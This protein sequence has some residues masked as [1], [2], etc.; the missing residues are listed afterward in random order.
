MVD[1]TEAGSFKRPPKNPRASARAKLR[2]RLTWLQAALHNAEMAVDE[3]FAAPGRTYNREN[4]ERIKGA[5][6]DFR[7]ST[8]LTGDGLD[9]IPPIA[10]D[11]LDRFFSDQGSNLSAYTANTAP[12]IA[13]LDLSADDDP[14]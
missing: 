9:N 12:L 5:V 2:R 8:G 3:V 4:L 7:D 14:P 13:N 10:E 1:E 6:K 11:S